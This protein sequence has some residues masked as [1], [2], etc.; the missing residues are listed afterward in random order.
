MISFKESL[1]IKKK[2]NLKKSDSD[3]GNIGKY[4]IINRKH[5]SDPRGGVARNKNLDKKRIKEIISKGLD[6]N[7]KPGRYLL[8]YKDSNDKYGS[9]AINI[10]DNTVEIITIID[11]SLDDYNDYRKVPGQKYV[12]VEN[13]NFNII[14]ID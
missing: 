12:L 2:G 5:T 6:K 8:I 14:F 4:H 13:H 3:Y 1:L 11:L 7:L 10:K 9:I